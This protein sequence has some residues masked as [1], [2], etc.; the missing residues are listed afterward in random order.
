MINDTISETEYSAHQ[1]AISTRSN[2]SNSL[3]V[4][5]Q[6]P[7]QVL[8]ELINAFQKVTQISH[9]WHCH[10]NRQHKQLGSIICTNKRNR[11][12]VSF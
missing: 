3:C 7:G 1:K 6:S 5:V 12:I 9:Y 11:E 4:H 2:I 10:Q 8:K